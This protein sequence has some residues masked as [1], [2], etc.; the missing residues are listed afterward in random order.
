MEA[1]KPVL[2][3]QMYTLRNLTREDMAGVLREVAAMGYEGVELAGYGNLTANEVQRIV[4]ELELQVVASHASLD[5]LQ[6][7]LQTV[8]KDSRLLGNQFVICPYLPEELRGSADNYRNVARILNDVGARLHEEAGL[9]LCYHN[10]AFE[11]EDRYDEG[12]GFDLLYENSEPRYVQAEIDTYW[13]Q[14]GGEN[15]AE[16]IRKYSGRAP[17]IHLK[18]MAQ[19][20]SFAEVG[21]GSLDWPA[22]LHAADAGGAV[23]YI[24]EQDVCPGNP[25]DSVRLS[26]NNLKKMLQ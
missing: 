17:L 2:A 19:D 10:H 14:K 18:D 7:D 11:F 15:P 6:N 24:V 1:K 21:T 3:V 20:G 16:Y 23:A 4:Q 22:I 25:L 26:L 13:V 12:Y 5:V 9:Q 8:M